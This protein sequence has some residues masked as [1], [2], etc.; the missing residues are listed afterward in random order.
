VPGTG[1]QLL[2]AKEVLDLG[3]EPIITTSLNRTIPIF[4]LIAIDKCSLYPTSRGL[5]FA[6][7]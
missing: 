4:V 6:T 3:Q 7:D 1:S 5:F 2:K